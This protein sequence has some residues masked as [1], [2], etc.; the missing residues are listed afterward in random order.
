MYEQRFVK[1]YP[2][3]SEP[4]VPQEVFPTPSQV[5]NTDVAALKTAGLSTRKAEYGVTFGV[6]FE[7][8][9][10]IFGNCSPRLGIPFCGRT[11]IQPEAG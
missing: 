3:L 7:A 6:D 11:F 4:K 10:S 8:I 2:S 1:T 9:F 5:V